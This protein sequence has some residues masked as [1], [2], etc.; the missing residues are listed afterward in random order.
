MR[1]PEVSKRPGEKFAIGFKYK[2]PDLEEGSTITAVSVRITPN[3]ADGLAAV[4]VPVI[5]TDTVSQMVEKGVDKHEYYVIFTTTISSGNIFE[6]KLLVKV[7][8]N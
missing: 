3:E 5:V 8:E 2:N 1:I 4:G 6:D 7:R